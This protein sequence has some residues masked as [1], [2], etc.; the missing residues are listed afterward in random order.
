MMS[1]TSP[2]IVKSLFKSI[3]RSKL[4]RTVRDIDVPVS[5]GGLALNWGK[6]D[7]KDT[8]TKR[9]NVLIY[10]HDLLNKIKPEKG[11][12][13]IPYL[14]NDVLHQSQIEKLDEQFNK[15]VQ[16]EE[17]HEDFI[18]IP[19]LSRIRKRISY[20][21]HMR[22]LFLC[23]N[24]EDLPSLSFLKVLNIPFNDGMVRKEIQSEVDRIF[25]E[26]FLNSNKEFGYEA[27]RRSFIEAVRGTPNATKVALEFLTPIIDLNVRPDYLLKVVKDYKVNHFDKDDFERDLGKLLKP[28]EFDLPSFPSSPNFAIEVIESFD[29]LIKGLFGM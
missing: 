26:N 2:Q 11:C 28:K 29:N 22:D 18:G 19:E 8:R 1:E 23:Q 10:L 15:P 3:N 17:Y 4:S 20:N 25:L 16:L 21:S 5:H 27:F 12:I 9:T 14:S 24:I 13:S 6:I 7:E